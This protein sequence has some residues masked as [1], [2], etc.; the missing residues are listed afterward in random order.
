MLNEGPLSAA[1]M[2]VDPKEQARVKEQLSM[3]ERQSSALQVRVANG[4]LISALQN[5]E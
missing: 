2:S 5:F 4:N 3:A 1:Q